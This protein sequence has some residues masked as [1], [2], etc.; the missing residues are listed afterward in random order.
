MKAV[1]FCGGVGTRLW[2]M[3]RETFPKQFLLM[4]GNKSIF[5]QTV[6]RVL[7]GFE[8]EDVYV[9]TGNEFARYV[10]EQAPEIP[11]RNIILEPQRRD[12]LGAVG[13]ATAY[14]HHYFPNAVMAAIWGADHLV[15]NVEMFH[16]ALRVAGKVANDDR[17]ICKVDTRPTYPST[18]NGWVQIGRPLK[19]IDDLQI[20]EFVRFVEKPKLDVAKR[21]FRSFEYLV[22]VGYMAWNTDVMLSLYRRHQPRVYERLLKIEQSIGTD[23]EQEVL[24][25]EY[26]AIEKD[27]VDYGIFEKLKPSDM[28]VIPTDLGWIDIGTWDLLYSGMAGDT[29]D[30][31]VQ[32]DACVVDTKGSLIWGN[33]KRLIGVV[34]GEDLIIVDTQ[35]ALLV[36]RRGRS[37]EV[38]ELLKALRE[39]GKRDI[40]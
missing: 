2:P 12:S 7:K 30:N 5:R 14:V 25:R 37:G 38:K 31:V 32:A 9:S 4:I 40:L 6:D 36:C 23:Q 33:G 28:R 24:A 34:G 29:A 18:D 13:Y 27:S 20:Y 11:Q 16:K 8:P 3:S 19:K 1:I 21:M 35:D 17:V 10:V 26:P 22:N 39:Q 15:D